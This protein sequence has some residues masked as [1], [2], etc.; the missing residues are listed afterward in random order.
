MVR[1]LVVSLVVVL[2]AGS[3]SFGPTIGY[4]GGNDCPTWGVQYG[5]NAVTLTS[6]GC[7]KP[8]GKSNWHA[9]PGRCESRA[10]IGGRAGLRSDALAKYMTLYECILDLGLVPIA[11]SAIY[12]NPVDP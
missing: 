12:T 2:L 7:W 3:L 5:G 9:K 10:R 11:Y 6:L 4:A 1:G 8:V